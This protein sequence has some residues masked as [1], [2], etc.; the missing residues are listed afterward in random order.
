VSHCFCFSLR[1]TLSALACASYGFETALFARS[2]EC[3]KSVST[4]TSSPA[5]GGSTLRRMLEAVLA[6]AF[7]FRAQMDGHS[8]EALAGVSQTGRQGAPGAVRRTAS[9]SLSLASFAT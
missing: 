3:F 7:H 9:S 8:R 5:L 1:E 4:S 6:F 2:I